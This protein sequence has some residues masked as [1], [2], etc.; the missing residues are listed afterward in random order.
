MSTYS[1]SKENKYHELQHLNTV[2]QN[3]NYPPQTHL[4]TKRKGN[5][6]ITLNTTQKQKW[7]TFTYIV[8][9]IRIT[10]RLFRNTNIRIAYKTKNTLQNQFQTA[11]G[12]ERER[13]PETDTSKRDVGEAHIVLATAILL[14]QRLSCY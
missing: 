10:A 11:E 9:E 8:K 12:N 6:S 3:N 14:P 13:D 7:A 5:K 1:I 4:N 2:L